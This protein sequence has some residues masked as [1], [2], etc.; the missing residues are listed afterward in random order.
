MQGIQDRRLAPADHAERGDLDRR[1]VELLAQ[2][3]KLAELAGQDGFFLGRQLEARQ[4]GFEAFLG[5]LDGRVVFGGVCVE[6]VE[7]FFELVIGHGMSLSLPPVRIACSHHWAIR[8]EF[9]HRSVTSHELDRDRQAVRR[10][11]RSETRPWEDRKAPGRVERGI[12][13]CR[14]IGR[15]ADRRRRD[16]ERR[17]FRERP[18]SELDP[19]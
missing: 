16:P 12:A 19:C 9:D 10:Q 6:L 13:G 3:A 1:L 17:A 14:R 4:G 11:I 2:V 8:R 18:A 15:R 7:Q 5:A